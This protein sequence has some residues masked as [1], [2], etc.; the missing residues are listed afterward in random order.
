MRR[1]SHLVGLAT[2]RGTGRLG[3]LFALGGD[4]QVLPHVDGVGFGD[5]VGAG[6]AL[7]AGAITPGHRIQGVTL[8]YLVVATTPDLA[9]FDYRSL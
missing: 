3:Y 7:D 8:F 4:V 6:D 1:L 2:G 5:F 9:T